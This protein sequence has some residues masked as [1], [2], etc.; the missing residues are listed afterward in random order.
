MSRKLI[1]RWN[2]SGGGSTPRNT[3]GEKES[4]TKLTVFMI[5]SKIF[6]HKCLNN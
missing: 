4:V 1:L 5:R 3:K 6:L 2:N